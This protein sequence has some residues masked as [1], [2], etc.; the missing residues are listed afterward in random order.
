MCKQYHSSTVAER[1]QERNGDAGASCSADAFEQQD[2]QELFTLL[3][4]ALSNVLKG[5]PQRFY[6]GDLRTSVPASQ[7]RP[8]A[9]SPV[10]QAPP[11]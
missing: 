10:V 1:G 2:V 11:P 3:V 4:D 5:E 8:P 7:E 9:S 6:A